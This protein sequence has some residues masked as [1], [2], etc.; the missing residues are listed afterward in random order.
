MYSRTVLDWQSVEG[1]FVEVVPPDLDTN[2]G[3][4]HQV[5]HVAALLV[6]PVLLHQPVED[7]Q[8]NRFK[9]YTNH[10]TNQCERH[11]QVRIRWDANF[12]SFRLYYT[13]IDLDSFWEW[14]NEWKLLQ[15]R[16]LPGFF[17][18]QRRSIFYWNCN[19]DNTHSSKLKKK[20]MA[21]FTNYTLIWPK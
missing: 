10:R 3:V 19:S 12:S 18:R 20:M 8:A 15:N 5:A 21:R 2:I 7:L 13:V 4:A 6:P 9:Q 11:N 16:Q 14:N 1:V 17:C